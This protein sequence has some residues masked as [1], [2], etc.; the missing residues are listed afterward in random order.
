MIRNKEIVLY[1]DKKQR[2]SVVCDNK[3]RNS[4]VSMITN[5]EI[6]LYL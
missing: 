1:Y 3:Q 5:K 6:V 2:N 4:V